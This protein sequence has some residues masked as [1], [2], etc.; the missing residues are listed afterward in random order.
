MDG[1]YGEVVSFEYIADADPDYI[2]VIDRDAARGSDEATAE[3]TLDNP[4]VQGTK[5]AQNDNI[6]YLSPELWY[7]MG[8]GINNVDAMIDEVEAAL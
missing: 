2:F 8:G 1:R 3:A 7:V 4:L 6:V 5:A